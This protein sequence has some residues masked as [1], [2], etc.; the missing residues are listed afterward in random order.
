MFNFSFEDISDPDADE[1]YGDED[2]SYVPRNVNI[3]VSFWKIN[4]IVFNA[5]FNYI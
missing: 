2:E 5:I 4:A 3:F 1:D